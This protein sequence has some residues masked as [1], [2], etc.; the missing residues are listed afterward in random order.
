M[1]CKGSNRLSGAQNC[2]CRKAAGIV[3][4]FVRIMCVLWP[5]C[6]SRCLSRR[7]CRF[8][9]QIQPACMI[10][11]VFCFVCSF[12][13]GFA[14]LLSLLTGLMVAFMC[15][16]PSCYARETAMLRWTPASSRS[17][18]MACRWACWLW[19]VVGRCRPCPTAVLLSLG[20]FFGCLVWAHRPVAS[21]LA[22]S[23]A[24]LSSS[25]RHMALFQSAL[26]SCC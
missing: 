22:S 3:V 23:L 21:R 2:I 14:S 17:M 13:I 10:Q 9:L 6:V 24:G 5:S 7:P 25:G 26:R 4:G 19:P 20:T 8:E 16:T 12:L 11:Q 18:Q 15:A 1:C